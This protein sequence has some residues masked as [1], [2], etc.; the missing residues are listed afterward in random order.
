MSKIITLPSIGLTNM[1]LSETGANRITSQSRSNFSASFFFLPREKREAI[2]HVYALFRIIDDVVDEEPDPIKQSTLLGSLR[3]EVIRMYQGTTHIPLLKKLKQSVDRFS[4]PL[5][6]LLELFSGCEMDIA[7]KRYPSFDELY[8]YCYRVAGIVGLVC[9]KIFE[10]ETETSKEAAIHLGVALQLTNI[11][12]DVGT[13]LKKGRLY[14]PQDE[15]KRYNVTEADLQRGKTTDSF[16]EM[17]DFQYQR[18]LQH[19]T[20]GFSEFEKDKDKKLLAARIMGSVYRVLLDKLKRK[21]Y[22]VLN[23]RMRLNPFQKAL[24]LTRVF[25]QHYL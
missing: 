13:D 12:R 15:L 1:G 16:I 21:K 22:P 17:M 7:Q 8:L 23:K 14:I 18:A 3:S 19:Y 20:A 9:M 24:I 6:Y 25:I 4:I 10:Y 2:R 5:D 11:M